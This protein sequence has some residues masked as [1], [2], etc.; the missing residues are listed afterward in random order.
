MSNNPED[1]WEIF[2]QNIVKCLNTLHPIKLLTVVDTKPIW[3]SNVLLL[4]MR[5]RDFV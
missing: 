1:L 3:L 5:N 2:I 4:Q